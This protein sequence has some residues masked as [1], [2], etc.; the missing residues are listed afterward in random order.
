MIKMFINY[1]AA[2][3]VC[4]G[5]LYLPVANAEVIGIDNEKLQELIDQGVPI[6]DV[7]LESEWQNT[8]V[9]KNSH[10]L[11]F[12]DE[13]G[14]YDAQAWQDELAKVASPD[15]AVILICHSGQRSNVISRWL[16][17]KQGYATVYNVT[18]GIV[19][20]KKTGGETIAP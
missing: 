1:L 3:V 15:E 19:T 4:F 2:A 6:I 9:I 7:R 17:E 8:G 20:W 18:T 13:R 10:L 14:S 12:F 16:S 11:T 5:L